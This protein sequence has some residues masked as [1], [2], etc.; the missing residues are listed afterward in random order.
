MWLWLL[1]GAEH[2]GLDVERTCRSRWK[3]KRRGGDGPPDWT[4]NRS[5]TRRPLLRPRRSRG[6]DSRTGAGRGI[7]RDRMRHECPAFGRSAKRGLGIANEI[8]QSAVSFARIAQRG[9]H[10]TTK[11]KYRAPNQFGSPTKPS[12]NGAIRPEPTRLRKSGLVN[13]SIEAH[14]NRERFMVGATNF[15]GHPDGLRTHRIGV[16]PMFREA[17]RNVDRLRVLGSH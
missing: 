15:A 17:S 7:R 12:G 2:E 1:P 8:S 10:R 14:S 16:S 5:S 3:R 11:P 13:A 4:D 6:S 9:E